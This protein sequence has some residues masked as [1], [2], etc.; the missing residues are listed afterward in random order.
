MVSPSGF[1]RARYSP[2]ALKAKFACS[3][4]PGIERFLPDAKTIR[5]RLGPMFVAGK[6]HFV[7][8]PGASVRY[9]PSMLTFVVPL[10]KIS[11]QSEYSPSSSLSPEV[12]LARN[13]EIVTVSAAEHTA[14]KLS[15]ERNAKRASTV[16]A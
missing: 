5:K 3:G 10:L 15:T 16:T 8:F 13:S 1:T 9:H 11:I 4:A 7:R 6:R 14:L 12:L 2:F